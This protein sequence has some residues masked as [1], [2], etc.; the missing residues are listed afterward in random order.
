MPKINFCGH[1]ISS[2][3]TAALT[4]ARFH[5]GS[6]NLNFTLSVDNL[7]LN[8]R[9]FWRGRNDF[10]KSRPLLMDSSSNFKPVMVHW[11]IFWRGRFGALFWP[12]AEL[13]L[14]Q[15][16]LVCVE[17]C[18]KPHSGKCNIQQRMLRDHVLTDD[19]SS[20]ALS[21]HYMF[22]ILTQL[23]SHVTRQASLVLTTSMPI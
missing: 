22:D 7:V 8:E 13:T 9:S 18:L 4:Q 21:Y 1:H 12:L 11:A 20:F 6:V 17:L 5:C 14:K 19:T 23:F 16:R 2:T 15:D 10:W 3:P